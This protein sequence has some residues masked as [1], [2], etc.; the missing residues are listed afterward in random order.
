VTK[1]REAARVA[2]LLQQGNA[3]LAARDY[4]TAIARFQEAQQL[5]PNNAEAKSGIANA[6]KARDADVLAKRREQDERDRA[7]QVADL[8]RQGNDALS[9]RDYTTALAR[10]R[11]AERL[12]PNNIAARNG[13][14]TATKAKEAADQASRREERIKATAAY[15]QQGN[16]ALSSGDYATALS[17][18]QEALRFDPTN[19]DAKKG[20]D[21]VQRA[22]DAEARVAVNQARQQ[23]DDGRRSLPVFSKQTRITQTQKRCWQESRRRSRRKAGSKRSDAGQAFTYCGASPRHIGNRC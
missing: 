9:S 7:K 19:A 22:R 20:I 2:T 1:A 14:A 10:F 8:V 15:V 13:I 4:T 11:E 18:F 12:D 23:Y 16:D 21:A 5:D 3:A 6:T 17:R